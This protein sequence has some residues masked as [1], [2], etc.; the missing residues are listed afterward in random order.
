MRSIWPLHAYLFFFLML[1]WGP[2]QGAGWLDRQLEKAKSWTQFYS[3]SK[4]EYPQKPSFETSHW[5]E[6]V[7]PRWI[8]IGQEHT[9]FLLHDTVFYAG[10]RERVNALKSFE[11]VK[12]APKIKSIIAAGERGYA[13]GESGE[14]F[15]WAGI[16]NTGHL[17]SLDMIASC[18]ESSDST[19][20]M[21]TGQGVLRVDPSSATLYSGLLKGS[22]ESRSVPIPTT[23]GIA[24]MDFG[25]EGPLFLTHG[26]YLLNGSAKAGGQFNSLWENAVSLQRTE[27][28][29][30]I[31]TR[32]GSVWRVDESGSSPV[33]LNAP[34]KEIAA[35]R[36]H[37]LGLDASGC[38]WSW[39]VNSHGQLGSGELRD[40]INPIQIEGLKDIIAIAAGHDQSFAVSL[41]DGLL[42]WGRNDS[43][44]LGIP[45]VGNVQLSPQKVH[46]VGI[47]DLSN[48][49]LEKA[50]VR[51]Y[52][53]QTG[54]IVG[55]AS[56]F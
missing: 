31:L 50:P 1:G 27:D 9:V 30:W 24:G 25:K 51:I 41:K 52:F 46:I 10:G 26:G 22:G 37:V 49:L 19:L 36:G 48:P 54:A 12:N 4:G 28:A 3:K 45:N 11:P 40:S 5:G 32:A 14:L 20:W 44:Q 39:G 35:G 6:R 53:P 43:G 42:A 56:P 34:L 15:Q 21:P 7:P 33:E 2:L 38:V 47:S 18:D 23:Q 55:T 17:N 16:S 8:G 13:L 29:I